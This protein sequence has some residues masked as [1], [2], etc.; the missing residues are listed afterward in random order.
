MIEKE[1]ILDVNHQKPRPVKLTLWEASKD[2]ALVKEM[3][4]QLNDAFLSAGSEDEYIARLKYRNNHYS[5]KGTHKEWKL[6]FGMDD[7]VETN[8]V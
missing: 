7:V 6:F 5:I 8:K 2:P 4:N 3:Y 1:S